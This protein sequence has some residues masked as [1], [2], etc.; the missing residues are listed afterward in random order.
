MIANAIYTGPTT[1]RPTHPEAERAQAVPM[2]FATG[3]VFVGK[4]TEALSKQPDRS[5]RVPSY[6]LDYAV[7]VLDQ[8]ARYCQ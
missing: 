8:R 2:H 4:K 7:F 6:L 3:Q 1:A 5:E